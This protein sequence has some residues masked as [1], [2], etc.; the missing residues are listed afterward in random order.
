MACLPHLP[1][2]DSL[3][4]MQVVKYQTQLQQLG[5][6]K[7]KEVQR[8][9]GELV[10]NHKGRRD[11]LRIHTTDNGRPLILYLKR[12]WRPYKKDGLW[13][14][15]RRGRVHSACRQEWDNSL[16]LAAA[17]L[18]TA[19]LVA[20]GEECGPLWERFSFIIT[21]AAEGSQT[22]EHFLQTCTNGPTRRRV[23]EALAREIRRMHDAGLS[24]PDLFTRHIFLNPCPDRPTFCLIDMAR[25]ERQKTT[26]PRRRARDLAELNITTPLPHASAAERLRFLRTYAGSLDRNLIRLIRRRMSYL[27]KRPKFSNFSNGTTPPHPL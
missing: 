6:T 25:M 13:S 3:L 12:I 8:F 4:L 11:I 10:K 7:L 20:Y 26:P 19:E 16:A 15:V 18:K 2:P 27:L 17:G 14:L 21:R 22:L 5:L 1:Q 23:I 9:S 24:T